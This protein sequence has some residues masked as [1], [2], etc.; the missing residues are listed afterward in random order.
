[1]HLTLIYISFAGCLLCF[2][3]G[4]EQRVTY[5]SVIKLINMDYKVRLHSHDV[6][7]GTGSGQQSVTATHQQED[8]N[9]HW[10][11]KPPTKPSARGEPVKCGDKI[12]LQHLSTSKNLHSHHFSS[13]LSGNQEVSAY[14][15]NGEGDSGD[16]WVVLCSSEFWNR[17]EEIM[18]R[19]VDTDVYLSVSGRQYGSPIS[20]Q[21]EVVGTSKMSSVH[22]KA[23]EGLFIHPSDLNHAKEAFEHVHSEL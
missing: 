4:S 6:N 20:G 18:L 16:H 3:G 19:H 21:M 5:G 15:V 1:M 9:S 23:G 2:A 13:P 8:V 11:I 12:R 14:G 22:W 10:L 7:Y 17:N